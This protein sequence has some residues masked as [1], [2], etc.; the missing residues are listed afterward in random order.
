MSN[1]NKKNIVIIGAGIIGA[2]LAYFLS[3]RTSNITVLDSNNPGSGASDHSFAWINSFGKEPWSYHDLNHRSLN[4]W[5]RFSAELGRDLDLHWGG[6][7]NW[8][9]T[10]SGAK[11]LQQKVIKLQKWGYPARLISREEIHDLEPGLIPGEIT[12][13]AYSEGDGKVLPIK[14]VEAALLKAKQAGAEIYSSHKVIALNH[15][16]SSTGEIVVNSVQTEQ[17]EFPCDVVVLAGGTET[18]HLASMINLS[19]P[20]QESPGVV[21]WTSPQ[22]Q[23]LKTVSVMYMPSTS[24]DK[25]GIHV[26]QD[27]DGRL[28]IGEGTQ[29]HMAENDSQEHA[30]E[31]LV[32][33]AE[34]LPPLK[35]A[36]ALP[37]I[38]GYRPMPADGLP[39][40]GF[41]ERVTNCYVTL[42]HSGVTLA[43]LVGSLGA[44]EI[45]EEIEV[46]LFKPYRLERFQ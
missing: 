4:L 8:V 24:V 12:A 44:T 29:E 6:A 13:A 32:R 23:L 18:S 38:V 25:P 33:T 5:H 37:V 3:K 41:S 27:S 34:F 21:I 1:Y 2:T 16:V 46:D 15:S 43:P 36:Q 22:P 14:V 26:R 9:N 20:Q 39:V 30:D 45:M 35:D 28:M 7:L 10:D 17:K 40:I 11:T 31:L 42:M 19:I